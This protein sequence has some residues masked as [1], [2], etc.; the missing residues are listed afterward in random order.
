[1]FTN[2][3]S[4]LGAMEL[5]AGN[6]TN[7]PFLP[8]LAVPLN[9][10]PTITNWQFVAMTDAAVERIPQQLLSMVQLENPVRF[11]IYAWGQ[12]LRPADRSLVTVPGPTFQLCTNY[13]IT[14]EVVTK[15]VVRIEPR[16]ITD[17]PGATNNVT[18]LNIVVE[19]YEVLQNP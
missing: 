10:G 4:F 5:S 17:W 7:S 3:G 13:Q 16:V 1:V 9:V 11:A 18:N 14:G 2:L 19:S 12:S 8:D 15:S 6:N